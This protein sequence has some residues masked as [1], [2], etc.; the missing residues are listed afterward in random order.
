MPANTKSQKQ[1]LII[2][3]ILGQKSIPSHLL[4]MK[5]RI[6]GRISP[7]NKPFLAKTTQMPERATMSE[8]MDRSE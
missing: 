3:I 6:R 8:E 7:L 2:V 4:R 5:A 1:R